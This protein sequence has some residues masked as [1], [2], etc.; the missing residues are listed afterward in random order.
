MLVLRVF[1]VSAA[2]FTARRRLEFHPE[3]KVKV[4][5]QAKCS[6]VLKH[7]SLSITT[8]Q[9]NFHQWHALR[10]VEQIQFFAGRDMYR[11]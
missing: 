10:Q 9:R 7:L 6:T 3:I 2:R 11:E 1:F 5:A 8:F 4:I